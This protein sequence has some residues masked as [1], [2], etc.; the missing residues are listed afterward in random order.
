M[1]FKLLSLYPVQGSAPLPSKG[2]ELGLK[3]C[4]LVSFLAFD[5]GQM[6][7]ESGLR[8][9]SACVL[10]IISEEAVNKNIASQRW[11]CLQRSSHTLLQMGINHCIPPAKVPAGSL[12]V[13]SSSCSQAAASHTRTKSDVFKSLTLLCKPPLL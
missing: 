8:G 7:Q 3:G 11:G 9:A 13:Q 5:A 10:N 1:N 6:Y 2:V 12:S 4:V